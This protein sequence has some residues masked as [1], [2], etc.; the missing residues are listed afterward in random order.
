MSRA[1]PGLK[2]PQAIAWA[3]PAKGRQLA[4]PHSRATVARPAPGLPSTRA[5]RPTWNAGRGRGIKSRTCQ[6]H[7][8]P[9]AA[10]YRPPAS[11]GGQQWKSLSA[12]HGVGREPRNGQLI[13]S[14]NR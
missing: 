5:G 13:T 10:H 8:P 9:R 1:V 11:A 4:V 12:R 6:K 2:E 14:R 3:P 7:S